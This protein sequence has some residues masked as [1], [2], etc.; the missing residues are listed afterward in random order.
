LPEILGLPAR[1]G[2]ACEQSVIDLAAYGQLSGH[3]LGSAVFVI[4]FVELFNCP[5][6]ITGMKSC[7]MMILLILMSGAIG[8]DKLTLN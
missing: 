4:A 6:C 7:Q 5:D 3:R 1:K 8:L 2:W